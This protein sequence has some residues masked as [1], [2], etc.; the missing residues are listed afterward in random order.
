MDL[1]KTDSKKWVLV[2]NL[3]PNKMNGYIP[4]DVFVRDA[5][6]A[7]MEKTSEGYIKTISRT[8]I[9]KRK[10]LEMDE[11]DVTKKELNRILIS[12]IKH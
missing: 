6:A 9:E 10:Y 12:D 5:F 8:P 4:F 7:V 3:Q 1:S 2:H 11:I